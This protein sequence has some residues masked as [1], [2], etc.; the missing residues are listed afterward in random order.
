MIDSG[1]QALRYLG[2]NQVSAQY[3]RNVAKRAVSDISDK[4]KSERAQAKSV[5]YVALIIDGATF[6]GQAAVVTQ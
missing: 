6:R 4:M 1:R 2:G 3:R 5:I